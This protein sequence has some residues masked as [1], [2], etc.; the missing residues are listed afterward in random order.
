MLLP[1]VNDDDLLQDVSHF[2]FIISKAARLVFFAPSITITY[3]FR[4]R[5]AAAS[6]AADY[7]FC[8]A[9]PARK[10]YIRLVAVGFRPRLFRYI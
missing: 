5:G 9:T 1:I 4:I 3:A 6:Q 8:A 2:F 7:V 10:R